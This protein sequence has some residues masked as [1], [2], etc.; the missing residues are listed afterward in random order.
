MRLGYLIGASEVAG[1]KWQKYNEYA[2]GAVVSSRRPS[3]VSK[4]CALRRKSQQENVW[5]SM[6]ALPGS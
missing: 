5:P 2:R 4:G 1:V 3:V 6:K